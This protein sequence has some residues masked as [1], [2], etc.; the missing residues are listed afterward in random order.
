MNRDLPKLCRATALAVGALGFLQI[1][2]FGVGAGVSTDQ[3]QR[4]MEAE[5]VKAAWA[6][7]LR[8]VVS[9]ISWGTEIA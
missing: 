9:T 7:A 1:S 6:L 4:E 2:V 3:K 5:V 8:V